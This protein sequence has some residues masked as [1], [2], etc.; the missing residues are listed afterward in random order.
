MR[1]SRLEAW[2]GILARKGF[3][4]GLGALANSAITRAHVSLGLKRHVLPFYPSNPIIGIVNVCNLHCEACMCHGY[5]E[6]RALAA[7]DPMK[8]MPLERFSAIMNQ[9]GKYAHHLDLTSP[10]E[11]FLHPQF[12]DIVALAAKQH[13]LFVKIDTNGH[14]MDADAVVECGLSRILFAVD[15]F[16]QQSYEAYRKGGNLATV[17]GNVEKLSEVAARRGSPI[18]IVV[19]FLINGFTEGEVEAARAHFAKLPNVSFTTEVFFPPAPSLEFCLQHPFETTPEI[20]EY[21]KTQDERYNLYGIDAQSG[22][23]RHKCME[24]PFQ[25]ICSNPLQGLY[26]L[27]D[28]ECY[29]CC[30]AAGYKPPALSMGNVF[31]SGL[32]AVFNGPRAAA[33]RKNY[34]RSGGRIPLCSMCWGNRVYVQRDA[35]DDGQTGVGDSRQS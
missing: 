16:S 24:K 1:I 34:A 10:G 29:P 35:C 8:F 22:R 18:E 32:N 13:G 12:Y 20:Y 4:S 19:K 6:A 25:D 7:R 15:G 14:V 2:R 21:W 23:C 27:P 31:E 5:P 33:I 3:A 9:G 28:G 17:V 11:A 30:F 26:I